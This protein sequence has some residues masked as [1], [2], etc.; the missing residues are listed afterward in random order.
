MSFF[1]RT[2]LCHSPEPIVILP[3]D[4]KTAI[5]DSSELGTAMAMPMLATAAD[6][7]ELHYP[8]YHQRGR[9]RRRSPP[10]VPPYDGH[11]VPLSLAM[12]TP[13][14]M[15]RPYHPPRTRHNP[16]PRQQTPSGS[17]GTFRGRRRHRSPSVGATA[18][19]AAA[20]AATAIR[21]DLSRSSRPHTRSSSVASSMQHVS[22]PSS[23]HEWW[24]AATSS[25]S[26]LCRSVSRSR[27][28]QGCQGG[29]AA[30][31]A[32][33]RGVESPSPRHKMAYRTSMEMDHSMMMHY[34]N[35]HYNLLA[36]PRSYIKPVSRRSHC[37][38]RSGSAEGYHEDAGVLSASSSTDPI[39]MAARRRRR[40]QR[41]QSR[42]RPQRMMSG[43]SVEGGG[44]SGLYERTGY[45]TFE[46]DGS[47]AHAAAGVGDDPANTATASSRLQF[48]ML[49][50]ESSD[51]TSDG[52]AMDVEMG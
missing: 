51:A 6:D 4:E 26:W 3:M 50:A 41:T 16:R 34:H 2:R 37:P 43:D 17:S 19:V 25:N 42:P 35:T 7:P 23:P 38:S 52:D 20:T 46:N 5:R 44:G 36:P 8:F 22:R 40:R 47:M 48:Q 30:T 49:L 13:Q 28:S 9:R 1:T 11:S 21:K 27:G 14:Q 45:Y 18:A 24:G 33:K 32:T 29:T 15:H 10:S 12:T 39:A 31:T